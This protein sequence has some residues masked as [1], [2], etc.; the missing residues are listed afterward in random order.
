MTLSRDVPRP[1]FDAREQTF[2]A[3][4]VLLDREG[5][6]MHGSRFGES[7]SVGVEHRH[8]ILDVGQDERVGVERIEIAREAFVGLATDGRYRQVPTEPERAVT[9]S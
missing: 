4:T 5:F 2:Y 7:I 1:P 3:R 6:L 8:E 9:S